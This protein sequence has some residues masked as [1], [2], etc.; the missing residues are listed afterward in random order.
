MMHCPAPS[1]SMA[2]TAVCMAHAPRE[3][4]GLLIRGGTVYTGT[5]AAFTGYAACRALAHKPMPGSCP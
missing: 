2:S 3:S 1:G 4:V 5:G